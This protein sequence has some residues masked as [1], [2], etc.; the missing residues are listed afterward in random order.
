VSAVNFFVFAVWIGGRGRF[1]GGG[2]FGKGAGF[3]AG[4][5]EWADR[6]SILLPWRGLPLP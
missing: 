5:S 1:F 2:L 4:W 3:L 6:G